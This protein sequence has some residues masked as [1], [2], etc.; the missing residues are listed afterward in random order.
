MRDNAAGFTATVT[1]STVATNFDTLFNNGY[2]RVGDIVS[3]LGIAYGTIAS[4]TS[5]TVLVINVYVGINITNGR[6]GLH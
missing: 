1:S 2:L 6:S 5:A 3:I 4:V